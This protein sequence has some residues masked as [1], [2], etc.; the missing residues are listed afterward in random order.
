MVLNI[1]P[2]FSP[3]YLCPQPSIQLLKNT[4]PLTPVFDDTPLFPQGSSSSSPGRRNSSAYPSFCQVAS[5]SSSSSQTPL[6]YSSDEMPA[7]NPV[8][9]I[10]GQD[11]QIGRVSVSHHLCS[12]LTSSSGIEVGLYIIQS[13]FYPLLSSSRHFV[14]YS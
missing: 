8:T 2:L 14:Q 12:Y 11:L 9:V 10:M 5:S 13:S 4:G 7:W 6:S 1:A 3:E